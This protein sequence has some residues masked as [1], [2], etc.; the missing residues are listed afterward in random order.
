MGPYGV[1]R[2]DTGL[3]IVLTLALSASQNNFDPKYVEVGLTTKPYIL[4]FSTSGS[5]SLTGLLARPDGQEVIII[6]VG[7]ND[8]T[9]SNESA[10]SQADNRFTC[11]GGSDLTL[12]T[13]D[14]V[15]GYYDLASAR[16]RV[17]EI[18]GSGGG[19]TTD[20]EARSMAFLGM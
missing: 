7:A 17:A 18:G 15:L 10:S 9:L 20:D 19:G 3:P 14:I 2:H 13:A 1:G 6:N 11:T 12:S 16:W 5:F 8:L 4:R